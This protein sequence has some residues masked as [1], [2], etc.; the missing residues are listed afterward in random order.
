MV[1]A[2][3]FGMWLFYIQHQFEGVYWARHEEWDQMRAA[4]E[5]ISYY[6]LPRVLQWFS[7]NIGLHHIHHVRPGIPNYHLQ[8]CCDDIPALQAVMPLTIRRSLKSLGYNL[9]DEKQK[10]LVSFRSLKA[11]PR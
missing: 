6:R 2:G 7:G 3:T 1:I 10:K 5:G 9:Y 4:L 11:L 8:Q